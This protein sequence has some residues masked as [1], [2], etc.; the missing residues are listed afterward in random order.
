MRIIERRNLT[1]PAHPLLKRNVKHD[2]ESRRY[3]VLEADVAI[4]TTQHKRYV[5]IL[6]QGQLGSCTGN[7]GVGC[8]GTGLFY[9]DLAAFSLKYG[10]N[11]AGAKSLYSA[12]TKLDNVKDNYPPT[13]TGSDGG[14]VAKALQAAGEISG[15]LWAFTPEAMRAALMATPL[16][17]GISVTDA[18]YS[19]DADGRYRPTGS[20]AGGHEI[21][22]AGLVVVNAKP[23]NDDQVW[24]DNS[25]DTSWG[26]T[27]PGQDTAGSFYMTYGDYVEALAD[28]GDVTQFVMASQPA[29][30]PTPVPADD[31]RAA[32]DKLWAAIPYG[33]AEGHHVGDNE[34]VAKGIHQF[35]LATGRS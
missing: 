31:E 21:A 26:V 4:Q 14:S 19:P 35:G 33:W 18:I 23:S 22:V 12:A 15:Y 34:K 13:D 2:S 20:I 10:W 7:A 25:W 24:M 11:E 3:A 9:G 5:P 30:T 27:R 6:N 29:P 17:T 1:N 28:Q 32:G 16:I 8:T